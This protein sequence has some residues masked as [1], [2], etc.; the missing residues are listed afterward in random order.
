MSKTL[1]DNRFDSANQRFLIG[2]CTLRDINLSRKSIVL[3]T[4]NG[5]RFFLESLQWEQRHYH[6][7]GSQ[8]KRLLQ[9]NESPRKDRD[10]RKKLYKN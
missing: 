9:T 6:P 8:L 3:F 5:K 2:Y 7:I 4:A 10:L 1:K